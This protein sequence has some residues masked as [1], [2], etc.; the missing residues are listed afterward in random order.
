MG[1]LELE[2]NQRIRPRT[3]HINLV[4]YHIREYVRT[5]IIQLFPISNVN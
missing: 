3:K 4:Y 1:A 2:K 5:R